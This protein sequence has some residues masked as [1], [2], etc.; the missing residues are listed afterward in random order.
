[1]RRCLARELESLKGWSVL[2]GALSCQGWESYL[3]TSLAHVRLLS[4]V[5]ALVDSQRGPLDELLAAV[6]V[7][8]HV[9]ANATVDTF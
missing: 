6:G 8:A 4:G 1:M 3:S 7:V 9:G 2:V 5:H